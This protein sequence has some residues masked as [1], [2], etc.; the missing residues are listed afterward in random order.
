MVHF[1]ELVQADHAITIGVDHAEDCVDL[2]WRHLS[3][4]HSVEL[5]VGNVTITVSIEFAEL[6]EN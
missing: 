4:H 2:A 3:A 5:L 6:A 1:L